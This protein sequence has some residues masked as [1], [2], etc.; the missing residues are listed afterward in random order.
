MKKETDGERQK[1]KEKG[2]RENRSRTNRWTDGQIEEE[3]RWRWRW[4]WGWG[5]GCC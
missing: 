4:G 2:R 5:W 1:G 3:M